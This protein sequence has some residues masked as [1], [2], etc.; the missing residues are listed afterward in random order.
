MVT[1]KWDSLEEWEIEQ[2]AFHAVGR[3]DVPVDVQQLIAK[4]WAMY[5]HAAAPSSPGKDGGQQED[6]SDLPDQ[7]ETWWQTSRFNQEPCD[8]Y[9][10]RKQL[11]WDAY[12]AAS[13][14]PKAG[15][16]GGQEVEAVELSGVTKEL[17][18]GSG[19]WRSCSGCHNLNEGVPTGPYSSIMQCHLGFGCREC[20]GIGAIWDNVDYSDFGLHEIN[21]EQP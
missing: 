10:Q 13:I 6:L 12:Y 17:E 15:K 5:C 4:L 21:E 18:D 8:R 2:R 20:G 3:D 9:S 16:D 7:F 1:I 19:F 11:A 14:A